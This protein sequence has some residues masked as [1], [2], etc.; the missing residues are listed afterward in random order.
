MKNH[1][2]K[3]A[4]KSFDDRISEISAALR[5]QFRKPDKDEPLY[6]YP[7]E[8]FDDY[9]IVCQDETNKD[10]KIPYTVDGDKVTFGRPVQVEEIYIPVAGE[11]ETEIVAKVGQ[12]ID[13]EGWK[14]RV[15]VVQ[16]GMSSTRD[17]WERSAFEPTLSAW[18]GIQAYA[19]HPTESQMRELP[20]RSVKDIVGWYANFSLTDQGMEADFAI[21]PSAEW[22]RNDLKAAYQAGKTD[23]YG[24]SIR[25]WTLGEQVQASDG[26]AAVRHTRVLKPESIDVV[27]RA[28]A[29]GKVK[30]ALA[31]SRARKEGAKPMKNRTLFALFTKYKDR[32][33]L[34]R[35]SLVKA[36]VEGVTAEMNEDQLAEHIGDDEA[37]INQS[38]QLIDEA[39]KPSEP[40]KAKEKEKE[41]GNGNGDG[42]VVIGFGQLPDSLRSR[43]ISQSISESGLPEA[44]QAKIRARVTATTTLDEIDREIET[45][46]ETLAAVSQSNVN[47][48]HPVQVGAGSIDKITIGVA[49]AFGFRT[50]E[51]YAGVESGVERAVRQSGGRVYQPSQS[52]WADVPEM[53]SLKALYFEMTGDSEFQGIR[54]RRGPERLTRQS[55]SSW[56][57][58]DFT[59]MLS[60]LMNK[61]FIMAYREVDY[62]WQR[63]CTIKSVADFKVQNA[64]LLGYFGDLPAVAQNGEYTTAAALSDDK[65][66]YSISKLGYTVD[67]TLEDVSNDDLRGF[68][69]VVSRLGRSAH[70]TLAKFVWNTCIF[71]NPTLNQ[72]STAL[73]ASG[74]NNLLTDALGTTGLKNA[75]TKLLSQTEPGSSEK[76]QVST[77]DLTLAVRPESYLD[78]ITLTDFNQEPG[79]NVDPLAREIRRLGITP[80]S[81]PILSDSNDW[82]LAA[83]PRDIDIVEVG[84][85]NGN[86]E[87]EFFELSGQQSEKG[88]NNDVILRHKV[89]HIYGGVPVDFRGVVKS[90]VV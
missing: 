62:G 31:S 50:K 64:I 78:A 30:Y 51:E 39:G 49:K 40:A 48:G 37:L 33:Q 59:D 85:F 77:S 29:G 55:Q 2:T 38:I 27:T 76:I 47:N 88:F 83:S 53:R 7:K 26:K 11:S 28:A 46:S 36:G 67:L 54:S 24:F 68:A 32:F 61:R 1:L 14:W 66:T 41:K 9:V 13:P 72:D 79:G 70:R 45:R 4:G 65:E 58:S 80:V 57:T 8:V 56:V 23:L 34:V 44:I 86:V 12:S 82:V 15:L 81:L 22:L 74:H 10:F 87:P 90:V 5:L 60:N 63:V 42:N 19:D 17:I 71:A 52:E 89:R 16:W 75:I 69:L 25:L 18:E 43:M 20:E 21:K 84:F 3:Q 73:F 35:Q 6:W